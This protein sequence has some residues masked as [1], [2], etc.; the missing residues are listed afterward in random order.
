MR[1]FLTG[2]DGFA[3]RHL[4][5]FL[6][7]EGHDVVGSSLE[8]G[9]VEGAGRV[10]RVDVRDPDDVEAA[11]GEARPDALVHL[12]GQT[13]VAAAFGRPGET[14]AVNAMGTLHVLEACRQVAVERV[15]VVTSSEVYG[16]RVAADGP[17]PESAPLAPVS[18]YGASKAAQDLIGAQYWR[19]Y[20]L[21][22]VR[23]RAFPHTGPGQDPRFVFPSV[24]RRIALAEAGLGPAAIAIGNLDPTRDVSHVRDVVE[25]YALLLRQGAA[26][27]A[28]NV[29]SGVGR[30][31]GEALDALAGLS[32]APIE[33]RVDP[34][35]LRPAEVPWMVGDPSLARETIGWSAM[36][37]WEET[38][39]DLLDH[40]RERTAREDESMKGEIVT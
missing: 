6:A 4:A 16:R 27:Q 31:I 37:T 39:R 2:I 7:A 10:W 29:C 18:P 32:E 33:F 17:V 13:S 35:R 28:Y 36:R 12:A 3:G 22:V 5:A 25:S 38:A 1:I 9:E 40:W 19:G 34:A 11:I 26:G 14:F 21:Q 15:L 23:V 20:D 8:P 24:A 30:T